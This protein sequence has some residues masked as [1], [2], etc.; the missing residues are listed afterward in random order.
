MGAIAESVC[1]DI[2]Q[3]YTCIHTS[4]IVVIFYCMPITTENQYPGKVLGVNLGKN[5]TSED[6]LSD[7]QKGVLT[8]GG[9]VDY[10]VINVSSPNTPGLRRMQEKEK[11]LD[12][13]SK[14]NHYFC[15]VIV[16]RFCNT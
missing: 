1:L 9:Y 11:L 3:I 15:F 10:I 14:V 12:L 5:K 7:Y 4:C 13:L 2:I 6:T 16:A 8:L